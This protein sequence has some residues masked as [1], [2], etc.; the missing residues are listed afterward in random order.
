MPQEIARLHATYRPRL[1][2]GQEWWTANPH[3]LSVRLRKSVRTGR[4]QVI[5]RV[6]LAPGVHGVLVWRVKPE[7]RVETGQ[8]LVIAGCSLV[9]LAGLALAKL[10]LD[11]LVLLWPILLL[12]AVLYG[13][14]R[15]TTGHRPACVG[16]HC[17]GC[18][19]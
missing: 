8:A 12:I 4:V 5:R 13:G 7:P 10:A 11:A 3:M 6:E 15:L 18:K 16:L 19:G 2:P 14:L 17:P 1:Q 9:V